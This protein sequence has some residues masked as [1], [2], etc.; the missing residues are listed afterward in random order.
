M[1]QSRR[2]VPRV[3]PGAAALLLAVSCGG[4]G[5]DPSVS[6]GTS[7]SDSPPPAAAAPARTDVP[8][9]TVRDVRTGADV[10]LRT[11]ALA[12]RP[13]LYWFWAPH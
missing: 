10:N 9:V 4:G 11:L 12:D 1:T 2:A 8:D 5:G 6:S 7:P 3:V 13:T